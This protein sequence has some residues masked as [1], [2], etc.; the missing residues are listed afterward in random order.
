MLHI[1]INTAKGECMRAGVPLAAGVCTLLL[2][3]VAVIA[4]VAAGPPA[5]F[6]TGNPKALINAA[7]NCAGKP[8][9]SYCNGEHLLGHCSA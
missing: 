9:N 5:R 4:P 2:V 8:V 7:W 1:K 6:C 3:C